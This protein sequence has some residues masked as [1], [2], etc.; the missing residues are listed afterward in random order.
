[1]TRFARTIVDNTPAVLIISSMLMLG[2]LVAIFAGTTFHAV[3]AV[4]NGGLAVAALGLLAHARR[5]DRR[6]SAR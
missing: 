5:L 1:M 3:M 6:K 4:V 2:A